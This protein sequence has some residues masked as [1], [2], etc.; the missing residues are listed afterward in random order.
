MD[1]ATFA[2][3][4]GTQVTARLPNLCAR[5]HRKP[6]RHDGK[7]VPTIDYGKLSTLLP[8]LPKADDVCYE[9][10]QTKLH[11]SKLR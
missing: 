1:S 9:R 3:D 7:F 6:G 2:S 10:T 11:L 4:T 5:V 8:D